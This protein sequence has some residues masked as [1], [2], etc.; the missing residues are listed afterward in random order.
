MDDVQVILE[1]CHQDV[2][3]DSVCL[4]RRE[5]LLDIAEFLRLFDLEFGLRLLFLS[6][7]DLGC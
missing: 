4:L 3:G 5:H 1:L 6:K 2:Q 7:V